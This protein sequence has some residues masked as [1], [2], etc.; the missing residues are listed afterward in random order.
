MVGFSGGQKPTQLDSN[1]SVSLAARSGNTK[2]ETRLDERPGI[3]KTIQQALSISERH[4]QPTLR[5]LSGEGARKAYLNK[6]MVQA[7]IYFFQ[8]AVRPGTHR[9]CLRRP[10]PRH[11]P[12]SSESFET[13]I[14]EEK[15]SLR[16]RL[17]PT[18][19][20]QL[21]SICRQETKKS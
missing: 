21:N 1:G 7:I 10:M 20:L 6:D 19:G 13:S 4:L 11:H 3:P 16:F 12:L 14:R 9:A 18:P 17:Q 15:G 2:V 5:P 8:G